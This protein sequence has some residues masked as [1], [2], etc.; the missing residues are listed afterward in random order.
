MENGC[1]T[2]ASAVLIKSKSI[3]RRVASDLST[4]ANPSFG[5]NMRTGVLVLA[6]VP[7]PT[8]PHRSKSAILVSDA[9]SKRVCYR[10]SFSSAVALESLLKGTMSAKAPGLEARVVVTS[11]GCGAEVAAEKELILGPH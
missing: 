6:S 4:L 2:T 9:S 1:L 5:I 7:N 3:R 8:H 10:S 11:C